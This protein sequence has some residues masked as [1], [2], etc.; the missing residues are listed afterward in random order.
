MDVPGV[1][2]L[3]AP[4][5]WSSSDVELQRRGAPNG[6]ELQRPGAPTLGVPMIGAPTDRS[7]NDLELQ[8]LG[9]PTDRSASDLELQRTWSS[10]GLELQRHGRSAAGNRGDDPHLRARG[11]RRLELAPR[12]P[13]VDVDVQQ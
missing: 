13:A 4:T 10:S 12:I 6:L 8:R 2:W 7:A 9:A 11:Q 5:T 3:G 1:Q